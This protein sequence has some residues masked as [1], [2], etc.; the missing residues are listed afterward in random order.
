MSGGQRVARSSLLVMRNIRMVRTL[1]L[2][3]RKLGPSRHIPLRAVCSSGR[4]ARALSYDDRLKRP[5][6]AVEL[7]RSGW[8][9]WRF[10]SIEK[11]SSVIARHRY[12][13]VR[14]IPA[15][16]KLIPKSTT[17][18]W[19]VAWLAPKVPTQ[20]STH[21][22]VSRRCGIMSPVPRPPHQRIAIC[23]QATSTNP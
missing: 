11:G 17:T 21:S 22:P 9:C 5:I 19:G 1:T 12:S 7:P 4:A 3:R 13:R 6:G 10:A 16:Q 14:R 23:S 8:P 2:H 18:P 20:P 15:E